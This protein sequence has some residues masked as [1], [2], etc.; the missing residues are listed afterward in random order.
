M[1]T[2]AGKEY[3]E[4]HGTTPETVVEAAMSLLLSLKVRAAFQRGLAQ[5]AGVRL[6]ACTLIRP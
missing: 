3:Y 1:L 5:E 4:T 2:H 6:R